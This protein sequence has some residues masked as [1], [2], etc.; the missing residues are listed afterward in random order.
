MGLNI[1]AEL[2]ITLSTSEVAPAV[3]GVA[4]QAVTASENVGLLDEVQAR[5][6][7]LTGSLE[8][9]MATSKLRSS[10]SLVARPVSLILFLRQ[11]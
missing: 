8:Q 7:E 10:G 11:C 1:G 3:P 2:R 6:K 9:Q 4:D 5:T